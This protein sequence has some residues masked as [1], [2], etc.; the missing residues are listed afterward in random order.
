MEIAVMTKNDIYF[1]FFSILCINRCLITNQE[2]DHVPVTLL[3]C[4]VYMFS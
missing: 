4:K 3:P 1:F 2:M